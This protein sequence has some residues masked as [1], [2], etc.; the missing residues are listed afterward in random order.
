MGSAPLIL[1][2]SH[3]RAENGSLGGKPCLSS[4]ASHANSPTQPLWVSPSHTRPAR[5]AMERPISAL[6][7]GVER[8]PQALAPGRG[9]GQL[10]FEL[11][12]GLL[13][14]GRDDVQHA[15]LDAGG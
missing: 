6:P 10:G 13:G 1:S 2:R 3:Q 11:V 12:V 14:Q 5:T 8:A 7:Q 15:G 9:G 4:V